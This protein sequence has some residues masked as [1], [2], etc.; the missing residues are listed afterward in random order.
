[1][2]LPKGERR[3]KLRAERIAACTYRVRDER[4]DRLDL[5]DLAFLRRPR[6]VYRGIAEYCRRATTRAD[7]RTIGR[8]RARTSR[9]RPS[10]RN[11]YVPSSNLCI[12]LSIFKSTSAIFSCHWLTG[13]MFADWLVM[14]V[15][16]WRA[17]LTRR[18]TQRNT[19]AFGHTYRYRLPVPPVGATAQQRTGT[20]RL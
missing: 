5:A 11:R 18:E 12:R 17:H 13:P 19:D 16:A 15:S 4:N 8:E 10:R 2:S 6:R 14:L 9:D 7:G 20:L 1:M 3:E